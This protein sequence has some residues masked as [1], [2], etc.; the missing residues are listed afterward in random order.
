MSFSTVSEEDIY[1]STVTLKSTKNILNIR[2]QF[3]TTFLFV[4]LRF[5]EETK[6][7]SMKRGK[8]GGRE[9]GRKRRNDTS[10]INLYEMFK[11]HNLR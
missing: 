5:Q 11:S 8:V 4:H 10:V 9:R 7:W 1:S 6:F 3:Y 2:V